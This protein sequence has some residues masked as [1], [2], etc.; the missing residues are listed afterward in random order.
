MSLKEFFRFVARPEML[1]L[2]IICFVYT[3]FIIKIGGDWMMAHRYFVP[4]APLMFI[5]I[6]EHVKQIYYY[7]LKNTNTI[8]IKK[9]STL[10]IVITLIIFFAFLGRG[11][12]LTQQYYQDL[13]RGHGSVASYLLDHAKPDDILATADIGLIGYTTMMPIIHLDGLEDKYIANIPGCDYG[14][15]IISDYIFSKNPKYIIFNTKKSLENIP[16]ANI[17]SY[18]YHSRDVDIVSQ[19]AF[20]KNYNF[21]MSGV[22]DAKG[23]YVSL[24]ERHI[25]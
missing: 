5:L 18:L 7:G 21:E 9:Y 13:N 15:K 14:E 3:A 16:I 22:F 10:L 8:N 12:G 1:L 11:Y 4:L 25:T 23:Y 19:P 6:K 24:F 17:T 20:I 2:T